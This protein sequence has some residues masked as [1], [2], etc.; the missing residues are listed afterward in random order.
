MDIDRL[1]L[2]LVFVVLD[3]Y[4]VRVRVRVRDSV[5]VFEREAGSTKLPK[6]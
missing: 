1:D 4:G 3:Q 2:V 5:R 6:K